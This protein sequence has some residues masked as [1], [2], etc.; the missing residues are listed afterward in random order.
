[1]TF[2]SLLTKY[3]HVR[4][5]QRHHR[6][7]RAV[8]RAALSPHGPPTAYALAEPMTLGRYWFSVWDAYHAP[9]CRVQRFEA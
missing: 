5:Q 8:V 2:D 9:W 3:A 1:M 4:E 6:R 7:V